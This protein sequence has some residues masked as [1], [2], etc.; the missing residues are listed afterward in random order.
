M[1]PIISNQDQQMVQAM[2]N[3]RRP[4]NK[5]F[6]QPTLRDF[7]LN[8][9]TLYI[10][11][12]LFSLPEH[13]LEMKVI[14]FGQEEELENNFKRSYFCLLRLLLPFPF[15]LSLLFSIFFFIFCVP[16]P[17]T[18]TDIN[19]QSAQRYLLGKNLFCQ[20]LAWDGFS[21][22]KTKAWKP[23]YPNHSKHRLYRRYRWKLQL[24]V[25]SKS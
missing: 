10:P 5:L 15:S 20:L 7:W 1:H 16:L 13:C 17:W 3:D 6:L 12:I 23:T 21:D 14:Y 24:R 9:W 2:I 19:S 8:S 18:L 25:K 4:K 22:L 11:E